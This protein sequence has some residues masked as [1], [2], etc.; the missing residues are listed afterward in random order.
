MAQF[1]ERVARCF[2]NLRAT[3]FT[4]LLEYLKAERQAALELLI[5]VIDVEQIY[6]LQGRVVALG[7]ILQKVEGADALIA[8]LKR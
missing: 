4:P 7:E 1:D 8:K 3:E 6:R 2:G 5:K